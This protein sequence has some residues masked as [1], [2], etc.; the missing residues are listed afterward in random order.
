MSDLVVSS[1]VFSLAKHNGCITVE[2]TVRGTHRTFQIRTQSEDSSFAPGERVI[3]L[4]VGP[5]NESDYQ[6]FGFVK[7]DGSV[8]IWSRFRGTEYTSLVRVLQHVAHY[9]SLGCVYHIEGRCRVCNRKLTTPESVESG[10]GPVCG[11]R[12]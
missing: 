8:R 7:P 5:D 4:L 11:G 2:N 6:N 1:S 3:G 12:S 9:E 10:L